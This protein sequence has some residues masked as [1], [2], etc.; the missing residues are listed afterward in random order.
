MTIDEQIRRGDEAARVLAE[1][2]LRDALEAMKRE[3]ISQW[4]AM[5]A[6]DAE[7]R[8]WVW[9]HYKVTERFEAMLRG[10]VETGK[11]ERMKIEQSAKDKVV[12]WFKRAA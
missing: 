2:V 12:D 4:S 7:G 3:I 10:F 8:E 11:F 1:P 6:R 5:P 9:R